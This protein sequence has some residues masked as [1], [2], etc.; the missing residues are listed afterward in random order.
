M[1]VN[2]RGESSGKT[3]ARK[4]E[5]VSSEQ[6]QPS[7]PDHTRWSEAPW[8]VLKGFLMGAADVVPGVSGGTMALI[9]GIYDR[10][11]FAIKS[12]DAEVV[13]SL[14]TF[15][16][17]RLFRSFHWKFLLLLLTGIFSAVLFFTKIVPL[18]IYMHTEPELI[19]GLFFGLIAGSILLLLREVEPSGRNWKS[20]TGLIFGIAAGF[21]IVTLVPA[22]TPESFLYVFGSGMIAFCAM[23]LPGISGSYLLLILGKYD[24]VLYQF[25]LLGNETVPA[26]LALSP[27]F[28]GGVIG[29]ILFSRV[30][31]W[32]L[33]SWPAVTM[34][35][36]IGFLIGSLYVIWPY[37][38]RE[39]REYV[40]STEV[41]D[42]NDPL[43]EEL[44]LSP[45]DRNRPEYRR[46]ADEPGDAS[47]LSGRVTIERV[48]RKMVGSTPFL[49]G[50]DKPV[51]SDEYEFWNG[52][53]G[54]GAG[55][56]MVLGIGFLRRKS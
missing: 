27:L 24:Y 8:L 2:I 29:L 45:P 37:Q 36:L 21:W 4:T 42:R 16:P 35:V 19:Y 26:L 31:T 17:G 33:N 1:T 13:R 18:Q 20:V 10:V 9:T 28:L 50:I 43:V 52:L 34:L 25:G 12:V 51:S 46:F 32:L 6:N 40:R 14:L 15:N 23:I 55:F 22:D 54:T 7:K 30:L 5:P 48:S 41:L 39:Y 53:L 3:I 47:E 56:L 38:E 49:P 44:L 11:I